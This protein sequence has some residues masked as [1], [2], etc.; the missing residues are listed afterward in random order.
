MSLSAVLLG[1]MRMQQLTFL[2]H[3]ELQEGFFT[4]EVIGTSLSQKH[5]RRF[6]GLM[7]SKNRDVS[8]KEWASVF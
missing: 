8:D 3:I 2:S 1:A 5:A 7:L 4:T 6:E